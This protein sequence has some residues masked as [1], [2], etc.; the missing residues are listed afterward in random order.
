MRNRIALL[1][2]VLVGV[3]VLAV[4][5]CSMARRSEAP[6]GSGEAEIRETAEVAPTLQNP[7]AFF[8]RLFHELGL[9]TL[10]DCE[11]DLKTGVAAHASP[12]DVET[13]SEERVRQL[14]ATRHARFRATI[15]GDA[16]T[17]PGYP[18]PPF[19]LDGNLERHTVEARL[20]DVHSGRTIYVVP[21]APD[22]ADVDV[23]EYNGRWL[24][25][26]LCFTAR[27]RAGWWSFEREYES[28]CEAYAPWTAGE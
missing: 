9:P 25:R 24:P 19:V 28:F 7:D 6:E 18:A 22:Q 8:I 23:F 13:A 1:A 15:L 4:V 2:G 12:E 21:T 3:G 14:C 26:E 5:R 27:C 10:S 20:E 16:S 11:S 17:F